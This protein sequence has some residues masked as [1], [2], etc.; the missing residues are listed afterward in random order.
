M[1]ANK[2]EGHL[3]NSIKHLMKA[4][5]ITQSQLADELGIPDSHLCNLLHKTNIDDAML[6]KIADAIG[7]GVTVDMIKK[8]NHDDT[9]SYIINN[10]NQNVESGGTGTFIPNQNQNVESGGTGTFIPNPNQKVENGGTGTLIPSQD[11]SA[12]FEEGSSQTNNNYVAEQAFAYAE[13]NA[14]LEKLLLYYRMKVEPEA[15]EKEI[16]SLKKDYS[17]E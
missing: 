5:G 17:Q 13:K 2:E 7:Y 11:N 6:Q 1:K 4:F 12:N 16:D 3:G 15:V 8:Y 9:I 10:Y 14:K